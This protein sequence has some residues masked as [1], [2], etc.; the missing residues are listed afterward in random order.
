MKRWVIGIEYDG[1]DFSGWQWQTGKRT[2]Q[3]ELEKALAKVANQPVSVICAGRTDA[4]VHAL[5]QVA[6]QPTIWISFSC[7]IKMG[8][9]L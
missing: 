1:S 3:A 7:T 2:V 4:G 6:H 9:L 5:E 8:N